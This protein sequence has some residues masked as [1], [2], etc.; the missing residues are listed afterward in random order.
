M[1]IQIDSTT[2]VRE[3]V[4]RYPQTRPVFEEHGIDYCCGGGQALA[5][6]ARQ[7]GVKLA[8][9]VTALQ[10]ALASSPTPSAAVDRDWYA[11]SLAELVQHIVSVHHAYLKQNLPR[12][13]ALVAKVLSAHGA[14]HGD[15]LRQV[16]SLY[17]ALDAELSSHLLKEEQILFP[18]VVALETHA[19]AGSPRPAAPFGHVGN[20]I[21]QMEHEHESAGTAL[22]RLRAVTGNYALPPD[23]CPTFAALY[24]GLDQLEADLHQHIHLENNILFPRAIECE[25]YLLRQESSRAFSTMRH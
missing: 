17:G 18:Y 3:L 22:E 9:L 10:Q 12:L 20:P 21:R 11:A 19:T 14:S 5:D 2:T 7:R 6:A 1:T 4:G 24:E 16:Q 25:G 8:P 23:A 13:R 15:M